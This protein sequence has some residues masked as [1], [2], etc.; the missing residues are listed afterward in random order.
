[1]LV[2]E[3]NEF[4]PIYLKKNAKKFNL[5]NIQYFLKLDHSETITD[6]KIEHQGLDPWV[7]W[8]SIHSGKP[9]KE[10]NI[11]R[12]GDT[13]KQNSDQIWNS[14]SKIFGKNCGF[15]GL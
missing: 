9:L 12:L 2:I 10:H 4:D 15:G 1:M 6:E 7:Q 13:K 3:L 14:V 8:V 5:K 11:K